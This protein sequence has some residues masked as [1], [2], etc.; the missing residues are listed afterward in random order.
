MEGGKAKGVK[1]PNGKVW[2]GAQVLSTFGVIRTFG[3]LVKVEEKP[4]NFKA[5]ESRRPVLKVMVGLKGTAADLE[6]TGA[7][8]WRLPACR[9]PQDRVEVSPAVGADGARQKRAVM[10]DVGT[11]GP[12]N[13]KKGESWVRMDFQSPKD[14][15]WDERWG[16]VTTCVISVEAGNE[17][18]EVEGNGEEG[19]VR[20]D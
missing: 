7:E 18:V 14:T 13:Y 3:S 8:Y 1:G 5:L 9:K 6:L 4:E 19:K 17:W 20:W 16:G 10:G 12:G 15:V 11:E 2:K